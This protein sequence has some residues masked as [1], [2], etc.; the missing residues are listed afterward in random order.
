M[1]PVPSLVRCLCSELRPL[2]NRARALSSIVQ[3][4]IINHPTQL[5]KNIRDSSVIWGKRRKRPRAV[6]T[7]MARSV[8]ARSLLT[9]VSFRKIWYMRTR[10]ALVQPSWILC[11]LLAR[12]FETWH[13]APQVCT[14]SLNTF[15]ALHLN[16]ALHRT[17]SALLLTLVLG[18]F[19][20]FHVSKV[21]VTNYRRS[22]LTA[23]NF[24]VDNGFYVY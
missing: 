13:S 8:L 20:L 7:W 22:R 9:T 11:N 21:S 12:T 14:I 16:S 18:Q 19:S 4:S 10:P 24:R 1:N 15:F 5:K 17:Q 3:S 2:F 6:S 23:Q